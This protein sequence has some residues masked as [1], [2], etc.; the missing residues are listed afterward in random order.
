MEDLESLN[1][2]PDA[3]DDAWRTALGGGPPGSGGKRW[4]LVFTSPKGATPS[5]P[6]AYFPVPA[7]QRW[8]AEDDEIENGV[9]AW[10]MA[11]LVLRG[12]FLMGPGPERV[13]RFDFTSVEVSVGPLRG[14]FPV[15]KGVERMAEAA[16]LSRASGGAPP[17][18]AASARR[19]L[20]FFKLLYV[21]K[22]VVAARGRSG[23]LAYWTRLR[24][25]E[26]DAW[27][28]SVGVAEGSASLLG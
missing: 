8:C 5:R 22:D 19:S 27:Q 18:A 12:P 17:K 21:G 15:A 28:R 25:D 16:V 24:G 3:G 20:P 7:A 26:G 6:G 14:T 4:R 10:G 1:L 13:L 23:G 9:Y 2:R 11:S